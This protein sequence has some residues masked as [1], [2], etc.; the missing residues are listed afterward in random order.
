MRLVA[1]QGDWREQVKKDK[2]ERKLRKKA[3]KLAR[4][5]HEN[6]LEHVDL[7]AIDH[8]EDGVTFYSAVLFGD[9]DPDI[10]VSGYVG[11]EADA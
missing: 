3:V 11:G 4:F 1:A 7:F 10:D 6:G 9:N 5:A 2:L 8:P